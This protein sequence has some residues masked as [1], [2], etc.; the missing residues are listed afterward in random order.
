MLVVLDAT[1]RSEVVGTDDAVVG[2]DNAAC[3]HAEVCSMISY[4]TAHTPYQT[5]YRHKTTNAKSVQ[6]MHEV[7]QE[8]T[9]NYRSVLWFTFRDGGAVG[10]GDEAGETDVN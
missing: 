6:K 7:T 3:C 10:I 1:T 8:I 5:T 9:V 4:R 2:E